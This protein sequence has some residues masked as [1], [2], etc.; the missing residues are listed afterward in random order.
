MKKTKRIFSILL[1]VVLIC[2][3]FISAFCITASAASPYAESFDQTRIEDDLEGVDLNNYPKNS[4]GEVDIISFVEYSYSNQ[5]YLSEYYGL[6][7]YVYNPTGKDITITND[8][9]FVNALVGFDENGTEI[10]D[11]VNLEY[12]DK[13]SDNLIYK[14]KLSRSS[15][16]LKMAREY[17]IDH[18]GK[19]LYKFVDLEIKHGRDIVNADISKEYVWSGF[20]AYCGDDSSAVSTLECTDYGARTIALKVMSTNYRFAEKAVTKFT[21]T[22]A[23]MDTWSYYQDELNSVFFT[24]PKEYYEDFGNL[25]KVKAEWYEYRTNYMYVTSDKDAYS[26]LWNMRNVRI[27]QFGQ[28]ID[29]NGNVIDGTVQCYHRVYF[30]EAM[31]TLQT[32]YIKA[33]F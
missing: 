27:N 4:M 25:F 28:K 23:L 18:E 5:S 16:F 14:F 12:L 33:K 11:S 29:E 19:R 17:A 24:I 22:M 3:I 2:H 32:F 1:A 10:Y 8:N 21:D 9:N 15:D 13:T 30:D 31:E 20:A 7:I 6:Y 26:A